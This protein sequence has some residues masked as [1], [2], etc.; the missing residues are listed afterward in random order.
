MRWWH[1]ERVIN[2]YYECGAKKLH[3]A[4]DRI[5]LKFGGIAGKDYDDF[6]SLA[7]EVFVDVLK[8]YDPS[9]PFDGFLYSCLLNR[10]KSEITARNR[11]KR[12]ADRDSVSLDA[13]AGEED[14]TLGE[15]IASDFNVEDEVLNQMQEDREDH[16][17]RFLNTLSRIQRQI[18]EMK[19]K[20]STVPDIR[21]YL[22]ISDRQYKAHMR[23]IRSFRH[24][25]VLAGDA[26]PV[27]KEEGKQMKST[28][29]LEKS[30][31]DKLNNAS[32][33][34]KINRRTI[35]FDHPLQRESDQWSPAMKS[36]LISDILQGNPIPPLVFAE[37]VVNEIA[38]I[39]DLDGKQRCTNVYSFVHDGFKISKNVRRWLIEYQAAVTGRNGESVFD[40]QGFPVCERREFD[41]RG[42][43]YSDLPEE[44]QDR[45]NDYNFEIIQYLNCSGDDIAYHIARY[46][47]GKQM[48]TSQ[49]GITRLG[50][51]FALMVKS[52]AGMP[53]F[54]D[55]GGYKVSEYRNGTINR[56][57][58]ESI[59]ASFF[60]NDWKKRQEDMCD[61]LRDHASMNHLER[62]EDMIE[63]LS[64]VMT[65]EVSDM[66][67]S[68]DSFLWFG[69]FSEFSHLGLGDG[70]FISFMAEFR[71]SLH[72]R[73]VNGIT[74]D[75]LNGKS[76]K[77]KNVVIAKM[78]HLGRL[79]GE[80]LQK[81]NKCE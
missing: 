52:I 37:Q 25:Q 9:Q 79:M 19:M 21:E 54:K 80:F 15:L 16:V 53:F 24:I 3:R 58:V 10:I 32:I 64:A 72:S 11:I 17:E 65:E 40:E 68:K 41:I 8:R 6:Y 57:A 26:L 46:N 39:W 50:E 69:L 36:N 49:K 51:E 66:F 22:N 60:L 61:F 23:E 31:P 67:D 1:T 38:I 70:E 73:P 30:K 55:L 78:K 34:K 74:F 13:P 2:E 27:R 56:V 75:V 44:L 14:V 43:K 29:T 59:M 47:E 18:V 63:R 48:T 77:D 33:I 62:F 7:N 81:H 35:R 76:T 42:K 20:G 45:F 5:L 4:V 28:Q 12:L 71:R